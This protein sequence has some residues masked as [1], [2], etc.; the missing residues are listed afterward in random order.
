MYFA[1][2]CTCPFVKF[3]GEEAKRLNFKIHVH[4]LET[5][6]HLGS[7][8]RSRMANLAPSKGNKSGARRFKDALP[9]DPY[10]YSTVA[11]SLWSESQFF[12]FFFFY[13]WDSVHPVWAPWV[14]NVSRFCGN[15][16]C[17][18]AYHW[19]LLGFYCSWVN[20]NMPRST[21]VGLLCCTRHVAVIFTPCF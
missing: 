8:R 1:L 2:I 12:F 21:A 7:P 18:V 17:C 10:H 14:T 4:F 13:Q 11:D 15:T 5:N 6:V 16:S 9:L 19:L 3:E 20:P